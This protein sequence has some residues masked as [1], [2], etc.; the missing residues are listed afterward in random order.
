MVVTEA[1][2]SLYGGRV[3]GLA[4]GIMFKPGN[5]WTEDESSG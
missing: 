5:T 3:V 4:R 2:R 1:D